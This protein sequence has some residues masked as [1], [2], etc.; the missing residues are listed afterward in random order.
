MN[1][2]TIILF[3]LGIFIG[4]LCSM[5]YLKHKNVGTIQIITSDDEPSLIIEL[6]DSKSLVRIIE[7]KYVTMKVNVT[8]K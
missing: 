2:V 3:L 5:A 1:T 6:N 7:N 8:H 4:G